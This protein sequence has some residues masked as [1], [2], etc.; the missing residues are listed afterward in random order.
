MEVSTE[1]EVVVPN[2]LVDCAS[3]INPDQLAAELVQSAGYLEEIRSILM[4][5][6]G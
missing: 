6:C 2:G 5:A 4:I 3:L 1:D